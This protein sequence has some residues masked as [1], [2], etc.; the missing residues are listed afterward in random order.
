VPSDDGV[1]LDESERHSPVGPDPRQDHPE[2]SIPIRQ[3]RPFGIP[4]QDVE[5][6]SKREVLQD[7]R[8]VG[9]HRREQ[10]S[11]KDEYHTGYDMMKLP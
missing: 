7:Q 8:A 10:R 2:G 1:G 4:L 9:L 11:E 6:M 5:L 3:A